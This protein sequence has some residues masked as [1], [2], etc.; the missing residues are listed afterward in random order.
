MDLFKKLLDGADVEYSEVRFRSDEGFS[1]ANAFVSLNNSL[2]E[3]K[4]ALHILEDNKA[5]T[6]LFKMFFVGEFL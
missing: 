1:S 6:I 4:S 2:H 3:L 5:L